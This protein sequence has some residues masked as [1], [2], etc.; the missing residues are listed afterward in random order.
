MS[1]SAPK[2]GL[3][4]QT[5]GSR[6]GRRSNHEEIENDDKFEDR[7]SSMASSSLSMAPTASLINERKSQELKQLEM[8]VDFQNKRI[9]E[10]QKDNDFLKEQLAA[11]LRK[12][13]PCSSPSIR[14][15][16]STQSTSSSKLRDEYISLYS[17]DSSEVE[18]VHGT[19]G[20]DTENSSDE[21][22][23]KIIKKRKRENATSSEQESGNESFERKKK[24]RM[25]R[26]RSLKTKNWDCQRAQS[27][28]QV[29]ARYLEI[30]K[31]FKKGGTMARAFKKFGVDRNTIVITA[32]IAEL[33]I[34][35]PDK[36][37]NIM[38]TYTSAVKLSVLAGQCAMAISEDAEIEQKIKTMKA[39]GKLIPFK[40]KL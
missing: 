8:K 12:P 16:R 11:A 10:L 31:I 39:S 24:R 20:Y 19:L 13:D 28:R 36:Y 9:E 1:K 38:Q 4:M 32:P 18:S 21:E 35:A 27:P 22:K 7:A 34:V 40:A 26:K 14:S 25:K 6:R 33:C 15:A 5:R 17:S 30:L 37:K 29:V 3:T 23:N 2:Q